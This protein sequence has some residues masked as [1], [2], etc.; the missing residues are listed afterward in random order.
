MINTMKK[1]TIFCAILGM[2][3]GSVLAGELSHPSKAPIDK[4]P[5][6]DPPCFVAGETMF[7]AISIYALPSGGGDS[8]LSANPLTASYADFSPPAAMPKSR[9]SS[10]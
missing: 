2:M 10:S 8:S 7:E 6:I 9:K 5:I 4:N 1:T 3:T